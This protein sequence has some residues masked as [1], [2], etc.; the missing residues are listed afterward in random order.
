MTI[1][2][3]VRSDVIES[4]DA[5]A[6]EGRPTGGFL[7]AVLANDLMGAA[8]HADRENS[9]ALTEICA[10]VY[11]ELPASCHGSYPTVDAWIKRMAEERKSKEVA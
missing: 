5:Y 11:N 3:Q 1:E 2:Y 8:G 4:L 6:K 10:Y 7:R 9:L